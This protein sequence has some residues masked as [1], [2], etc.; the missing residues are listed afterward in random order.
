LR[1]VIRNAILRITSRGPRRPLPVTVRKLRIYILPTNRGYLFA[2]V[3]LAMLA[4]SLNYN[5][6]PGFLFAFL[7]AA[8]AMMSTLYTQK[9][10]KELTLASEKHDPVFAGD[11]LWFDLALKSDTIPCYRI[12]AGFQDEETVTRDIPAGEAT[13]FRLP[14]PTKKRGVFN[15][16]RLILSSTYPF[17]LFRTWVV[18]R[19]ES[20]YLVFPKPIPHPFVV[21]EDTRTGNG[22]G[23]SGRPGTDDFRD[24]RTYQ[25]GDPLN[26]I[27]WKT[28]ARG[29]GL[30]S[31]TFESE[32]GQAVYVSWD[33]IHTTQR[34]EK[35][36]HLCH[37]VME[38]HR[39][40]LPYGLKLPGITIRPGETGGLAHRDRCLTALAMMA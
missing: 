1:G 36:S 22:T 39:S 13:T 14:L 11:R 17:G 33:D 29:Q 8:M 16:E 12:S 9:N 10:L 31:K 40:G 28:L 4:G 32:S 20:D 35:I 7:L 38:A 24:L 2:C 6:N 25:P 27:A 30:W 5:N 23:T 26:R 3:I 34:E 37:L 19:M 15:P 18:V 21:S